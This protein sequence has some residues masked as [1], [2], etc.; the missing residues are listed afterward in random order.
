MSNTEIKHGLVSKGTE[1]DGDCLWVERHGATI[2]GRIGHPRDLFALHF[3]FQEMD[4]RAKE[5]GTV[6]SDVVGKPLVEIQVLS[7]R[8]QC[9]DI[10]SKGKG[11]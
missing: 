11:P 4:H 10:Q 9:S 3:D 6:G 2:Y 8:S 7:A 1:E 5:L